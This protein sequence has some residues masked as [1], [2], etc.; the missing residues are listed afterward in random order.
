MPPGPPPQVLKAPRPH[1]WD[2]VSALPKGIDFIFLSNCRHGSYLATILTWFICSCGNIWCLTLTHR[3][4]PLDLPAFAPSGWW[5]AGHGAPLEVINNV[6]YM[7]SRGMSKCCVGEVVVRSAIS[8]TNKWRWSNEL[9]SSTSERQR[10][11]TTAAYGS[12]PIA[13]LVWSCWSSTFQTFT[14]SYR[15]NLESLP[16]LTLPGYNFRSVD[17]FWIVVN[18]LLHRGH[19]V[20]SQC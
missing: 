12:S 2:H 14:L 18:A 5:P 6:V 7:L 3:P 17:C 16:L 19:D 9:L 15:S 20:V 10:A 8:S 1:R 4:F 13:F 11:V